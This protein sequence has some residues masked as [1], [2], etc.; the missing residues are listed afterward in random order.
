MGLY[1]L[2]DLDCRGFSSPSNQACLSLF[3][4][5]RAGHGARHSLSSQLDQEAVSFNRKS[6]GLNMVNSSL[7][8][9]RGGECHESS[10]LRLALVIGKDVHLANVHVQSL[11]GTLESHLVSGEVDV[12]DVAGVSLAWLLLVPAHRGGEVRVNILLVVPSTATS[13]GVRG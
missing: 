9:I 3:F 8:F 5:R 11:E 4:L 12:T 1:A 10:S 13:I 6:C 2:I 7:S